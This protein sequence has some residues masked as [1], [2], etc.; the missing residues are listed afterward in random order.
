MARERQDARDD[1]MRRRRAMAE[2]Q[3]AD[4][5]RAGNPVPHSSLMYASC[6]L[7][8]EKEPFGLPY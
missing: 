6:F 3:T 8:N 1:A 2:R 5:G 4:D 7:S